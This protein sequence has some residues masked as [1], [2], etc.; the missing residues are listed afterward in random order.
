MSVR[1]PLARVE[2]LGSAHSGTAHFWRQRVSSVALVPLS[3]WFVCIALTLIGSDQGTAVGILGQP[4]NA[5]LMALFVIAGLHHTVLG[6]QVVIED[7]VHRE[8][9]KI[10]LLVLNQFFAWI[11]GAI[12]LFAL[13]RIALRS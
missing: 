6:L 13:V 12:S 4:L 5:I 9:S 3:I 2:G 1:T 11:A 8:S 10:V 7:Y